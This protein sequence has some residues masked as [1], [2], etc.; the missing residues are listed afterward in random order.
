MPIKALRPRY[1]EGYLVGKY[2]FRPI[3]TQGDDLANRMVAK[4]FVDNSDGKFWD[5]FF[6]PM[7]NE[8]IYPEND[9]VGVELNKIKLE[10]N[11]KYH[12]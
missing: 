3:K 12:C 6:L 9:E 7:P 2:P 4:F 8:V 10:F 1:Q 5:T 11:K